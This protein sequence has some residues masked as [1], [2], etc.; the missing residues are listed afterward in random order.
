[1]S[2]TAAGAAIDRLRR[3]HAGRRVLL[4]ED[5]PIA[6]AITKELVTATGLAVEVVADGAAAVAAV[7]RGGVDLVLMDLQMP[8]MDGLEAT[9][10]LRAAGA[11]LPIVALTGDGDARAQ[12]ECLAAGMNDHMPK[13][14]LARQLYEALLRW[15]PASGPI[16]GDALLPGLARIDGL[17]ASVGLG[18]VGG[19]PPALARVLRRFADTY[20]AGVPGLAA[21][22]TPRE[23]RD[24]AHAL[25]GVA[26]TLGAVS[27]QGRLEDLERAH[28]AGLDQVELGRLAHEALDELRG[29]VA[30]LDGALGR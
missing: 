24:A 13:P 30:A 22:Q 23:R 12:S 25:R 7:G 15:L 20:R 9:R 10:A 26:A 14:V 4:A 2:T 17:D 18:N 6:R 21:P 1:M 11:T 28:D 3:E 27:L 8:G 29:L 19:S 16:A 5:N